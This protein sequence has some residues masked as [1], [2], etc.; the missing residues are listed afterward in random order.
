MT[1]SGYITLIYLRIN[2]KTSNSFWR[3]QPVIENM[4]DIK[5]RWAIPKK[6][7]SAFSSTIWMYY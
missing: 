3:N 6:K 5:Y 4:A 1:L 2:C 7:K